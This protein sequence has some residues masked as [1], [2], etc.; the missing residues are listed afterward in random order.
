M[1]GDNQQCKHLGLDRVTVYLPACY[2]SPVD[3]VRLIVMPQ[4]R[5][6]AMLPG[7]RMELRTE[8]TPSEK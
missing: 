2:L 8:V 6:P 1:D 5:F 3:V 4:V 7:G